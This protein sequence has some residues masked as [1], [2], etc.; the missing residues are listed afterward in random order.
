M[1]KPD[2]TNKQ[3]QQ[4]KHAKLKGRGLTQFNA[5]VP[6]SVVA[7]LRERIQLLQDHPHLEFGR[8]RDPCEGNWFPVAL[9]AATTVAR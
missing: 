1:P 8:M 2:L 7:N 6:P 4:R 3:R 9:C 5:W